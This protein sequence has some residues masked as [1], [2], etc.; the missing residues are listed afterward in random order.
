V[1]V[2][3]TTLSGI[4]YSGK[5]ISHHLPALKLKVTVNSAMSYRDHFNPSI[6]EM[7]NISQQQSSSVICVTHILSR[8]DRRLDLA[9]CTGS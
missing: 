8:N 3:V 4:Y 5:V 2:C 9:V 7:P 6:P 1:Y